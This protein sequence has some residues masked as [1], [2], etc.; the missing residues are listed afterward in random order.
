VGVGTTTERRLD[1]HREY[2]RQRGCFSWR[3]VE[4]YWKVTLKPCENGVRLLCS[5]ETGGHT[6]ASQASLK[7]ARVFLGV[8]TAMSTIPCEFHD[9]F[10]GSCPRLQRISLGLPMTLGHRSHRVK[11]AVLAEI[12]VAAAW[13]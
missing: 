7:S 2:E 8:S 6:L 1:R 4:S 3:R 10:A 13:G 11:E 5:Q 12:P 9:H